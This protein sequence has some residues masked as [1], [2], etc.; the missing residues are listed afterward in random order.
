LRIRLLPTPPG[1]SPGLIE[2]QEKLIDVHKRALHLP[3][4]LPVAAPEI[5]L[6]FFDDAGRSI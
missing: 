4:H 1:S 6:W 3:N 5:L 2:S